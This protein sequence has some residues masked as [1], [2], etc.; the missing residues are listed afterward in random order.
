M[1]PVYLDALLL[2]VLA[3]GAVVWLIR[4]AWRLVRWWRGRRDA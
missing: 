2:G 4:S 3:I 1:S